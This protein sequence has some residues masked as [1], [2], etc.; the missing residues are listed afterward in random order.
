MRVYLVLTFASTFTIPLSLNGSSN[1][2]PNFAGNVGIMIDCY[3]VLNDLLLFSCLLQVSD[4]FV[5]DHV[6][7]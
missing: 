6:L 2:C 4:A 1:V 5:E 7:P 3:L